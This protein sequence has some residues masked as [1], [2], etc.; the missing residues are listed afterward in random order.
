MR[1]GTRTMIVG[2]SSLPGGGKDFIA[3]ILVND[4]GFYKV[5]PGDI[6]R[7]Y[8][9][10]YGDGITR[11]KQQ[12]IQKDLRKKYGND[13]IMEL[14]YQRILHSG[15][16]KIAIPGIRLPTD[17]TFYKER[18]GDNF[19]NVFIH[20]PKKLRFDRMVNRKREDA[21]KTYSE[22]LK[23]DA[24]ETRMFNIDLTMR[25]SDVSIV[26]DGTKAH[27]KTELKKILKGLN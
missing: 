25:M 24:R 16:R 23:H 12:D 13:Y 26:N 11:E 8:M 14:C 6:I 5:S 22:F 2:L 19:T 20:A 17:I 10:K 27:I 9:K 15:K 21:P 7:K 1:K 3:D 4:Y 18:F